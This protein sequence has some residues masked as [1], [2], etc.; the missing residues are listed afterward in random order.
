MKRIEINLPGQKTYQSIYEEF[1]IIA[2]VDMEYD[3]IFGVTHTNI[4]KNL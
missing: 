2:K 4:G 1:L 3:H